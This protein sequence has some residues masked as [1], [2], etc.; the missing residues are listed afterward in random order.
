M[1]PLL[2]VTGAYFGNGFLNTKSV[3]KNYNNESV[4]I[5]LQNLRVS[6]Q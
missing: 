5:Y 4:Y 1:K 6:Q 3:V 2:T